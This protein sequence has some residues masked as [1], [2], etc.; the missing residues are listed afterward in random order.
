MAKQILKVDGM[1]C[2]YRV[3]EVTNTVNALSGVSNVKASLEENNAAAEYDESKVTL[4]AIKAAVAEEG[5][6]AVA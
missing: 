4:E 3:K 2:E 1:S 5:Y 6:E